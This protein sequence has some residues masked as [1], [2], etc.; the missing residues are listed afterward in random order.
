[1]PQDDQPDI[2]MRYCVRVRLRTKAWALNGSNV[3]SA[4]QSARSRRSSKK[5][6]PSRRRRRTRTE[7]EWVMP[8]G[9]RRRTRRWRAPPTSPG[10]ATPESAEGTTV[11]SALDLLTWRMARA[12]AVSAARA[13]RSTR[14]LGTCLSHV[15]ERGS[16][17]A[18]RIPGTRVR[19][20]S[21]GSNT[22][23]NVELVVVTCSGD[24]TARESRHSARRRQ[25]AVCM[26]GA[27]RAS[28]MR[29]AS[30]S[31][32]A[33]KAVTASSALLRPSRLHTGSTCRRP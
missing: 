29:R 31:I 3:G 9:R 10:P 1:M 22:G 12:R 7:S 28:S 33:A 14:R 19:T 2:V 21:A 26:S 32:V 30:V 25:A 27:P 23:Q 16:G 13:V 15:L 18:R 20:P 24:V 17:W 4:E 8:S 5:V 6:R 11:G